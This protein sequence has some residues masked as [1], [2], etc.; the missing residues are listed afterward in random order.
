MRK[1]DSRKRLP[2]WAWL[3]FACMGL[4]GLLGFAVGLSSL[5]HAGNIGKWVMGDGGTVDPPGDPRAFDPVAQYP[6]VAAFAGPGV[7]LL[8]MRAEQ[9][10]S[11]GRLDLGADY[12][13]SPRAQYDF[14]REVPAPPE[15]PPLGAGAPVD[16]R[17][18]QRI[19]VDLSRPGTLRYVHKVGKDGIL[20][21]QYVLRGMERR[22]DEPTGAPIESG[23]APPACPL[24]E[25]WKLA[26][27]RGVPANAVASIEY[28]RDG[29][30]FGV[31]GTRWSL[32]FAAECSL[33]PAD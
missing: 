18:H 17:W 20:E 11:D 25:L 13:P 1:I 6:A 33:Q 15:A 4:V 23:I 26:L 7:A 8:R 27:A 19:E 16:G 24:R 3:L 32:H 30:D 21:T 28:D 5:F 9:V 12:Q 22:E 14:V 2:A 10:R 29:Y 31:R